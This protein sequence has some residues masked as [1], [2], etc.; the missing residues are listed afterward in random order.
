MNLSAVATS[1]VLGFG[2]LG[3]AGESSPS[4][5]PDL[6]ES[7]STSPT[8][9]TSVVPAASTPVERVGVFLHW[10]GGGGGNINADPPL[11]SCGET[12]PDLVSKC[13]FPNGVTVRLTAVPVEGY[14]FLGW[15]AACSA[16]G[17]ARTCELTID[18][19]TTIDVII[20]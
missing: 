20:R 2:A 6:M 14:E 5:E 12:T 19:E 7:A 13:T 17:S 9:S 16:A 3:C 10:I 4:T 18:G 11:L 1:I 15:G 8:P